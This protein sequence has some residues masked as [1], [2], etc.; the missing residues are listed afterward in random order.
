MRQAVI[1][2]GGKGTRLAARLNGR[3]KPLVDVLGAPLLERQ[4]EQLKSAGVTHVL[5]LVNHM[6]EQIEAFCASR[7]NWGLNIDLIDD[8]A[9]RGTAGAVF[10]A[11]DALEDEFLVIYGDT[12]FEIDFQRFLDFHNASPSAAA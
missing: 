10:R 11:F 12:L 5:V 3:P 9:P 8:G 4:I 1:L 6:A 2:A 7:D